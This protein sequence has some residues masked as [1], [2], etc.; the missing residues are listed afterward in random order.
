MEDFASMNFHPSYSD[1]HADLVLLSKDGVRFR[2]HS[3]ILK[4]ASG[5]FR[6]MLG[7]PKAESEGPEDAIPM[8]ENAD[9]IGAL[10]DTVFPSYFLKYPELSSRIVTLADP[11]LIAAGKYD[12]TLR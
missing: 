2:V 11:L 4:L 12:S 5:F 3:L 9:V 8:E 1:V 7:I 10:L 6:G